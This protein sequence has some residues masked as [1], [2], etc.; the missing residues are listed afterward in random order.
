MLLADMGAAVI[1]VERT[2]SKSAHMLDLGKYAI[3]IRG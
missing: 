1:L 3:V 2:A